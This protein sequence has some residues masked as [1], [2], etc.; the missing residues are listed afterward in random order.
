[1]GGLRRGVERQA[2]VGGHLGG[3]GPPLERAWSNALV[4]HLLPDDD[5]AAV[6]QRLVVPEL[7]GEAIVRPDLRIE[8]RLVF[9]RLF[10]V[11]H[12]REGV[13]VDH[14]ELGG[15]GSRRGRVGGDDDDRLTDE[16]DDALGEH[17][18]L[19][20]LI[21]HGHPGGKG[22]HSEIGVEKDAADTVSGA[23]LLH[24]D[25]GD[26]GMRHRGPHEGQV[27]AHREDRGRLR[28]CPRR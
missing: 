16:T 27:D 17:R 22:R 12:D 2:T 15:V 7:E 14:D 20:V 11:D 8:Q 3:G 10:R 26:A 5:V 13:V 9:Q 23:R 25:G 19:H 21:E 6:E 28:T 18:T 4:D 24:V 1:M